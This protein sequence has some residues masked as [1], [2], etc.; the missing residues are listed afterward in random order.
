ML[1]LRTAATLALLVPL[2]PAAFAQ[3]TG[4]L[5]FATELDEVLLDGA[6]GLATA[7]LI[8]PDELAVVT[9]TAGV[10]SARPFLP[11]GTQWAYLGDADQDGRLVD[12]STGGPGNDVD[13]VFVKR[14]V[15]APVGPVGPRDVFFSKEETEGFDTTFEDSDVVRFRPG[16]VLERFISEAQLVSL[17][18]QGASGDVDLDAL[19]QTPAG[20]LL[21]SFS[22][23]ELV[24][25][26][27]VDDGGIVFIPSSGL[28]YDAQGNVSA[29]QAGAAQI[30][31]DEP[32]VFQ[33][34]QNSGFATSVGGN[35]STLL[36]LSGL[37][38]DA[39]NSSP[40]NGLHVLF[41]WA[42]FSNDGA[43]LSTFNAGSIP[44]LNGQPL[45][46]TVATVGTQIGLLPDSSGLQGL[47]GIALVDGLKIIPTLENHPVNLITSSTTLFSRREL[48]GATPG[49]GVL[50]FVEV[51][52]TATGSVL[53]STQLI[54][55]GELFTPSL[56]LLGSATADGAGV[57]SRIDFY[58]QTL[59]GS[60]QNLVF[61]GFDLA[62]F[63]LSAPAGLQFL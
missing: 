3:H 58:P 4:S 47:G 12:S 50:F 31:L 13:A 18:G 17:V 8:N 60:D 46:S 29:V 9:P 33:I 6:S 20:D 19:C 35:P 30:F 7:G 21:C 11:I 23:T 41:T 34:I 49:G 10:Y 48:T 2:A 44:T 32:A 36:E 59:V 27:T 26:L 55:I 16:G 57:A 37:E 43:V 63:Q 25:G 51:G 53:P 40:E 22:S 62:T 28:T 38:Y 15:G 45:A 5:I 54:G 39:A 61:Q 42:G 56:I 1:Q 14:A 52:P 24:N